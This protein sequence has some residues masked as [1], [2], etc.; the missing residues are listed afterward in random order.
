M[1]A[2]SRKAL[3]EER[4]PE[5]KGIYKHTAEQL[6]E[7]RTSG[8]SAAQ[9]QQAS[10]ASRDHAADMSQASR[11]Q[12]ISDRRLADQ[13]AERIGTVEEGRNV[14]PTGGTGFLC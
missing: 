7:Q 3:L 12:E 2:F 10:R 5:V 14:L 6:Q 8:P 11:D 1:S 4:P 9:Q 13:L